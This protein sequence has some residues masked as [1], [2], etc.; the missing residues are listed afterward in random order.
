[1]RIVGV[2]GVVLAAGAGRRF[3]GAKALAEHHG[4]LLV[5]RAVAVLADGGCS[6]IVVVLGAAADTVRERAA[7][8]GTRVVVNDGWATGMGS[9]LRAALTALADPTPPTEL[10]APTGPT[11][12]TGVEPV[13]ALVLLVDLPG[14]TPAAVARVA[15]LAA[16]GGPAELAAATYR[17]RRGHPVLLGRAHWAG[18]AALAVGDTGA[19]PYLAR[20][21]VTAVACDDVA[22]GG[23]ADTPAELAA[24]R[25]DDTAGGPTKPGPSRPAGGA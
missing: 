18:V 24:H 21:P 3:G 16:E 4:Q 15:G 22:D 11:A 8:A 12:P 17:G 5:D 20:H 14:V 9:S 10:T 1:M 2:A 19:R 23:D 6:P 13:A 25:P 7:L